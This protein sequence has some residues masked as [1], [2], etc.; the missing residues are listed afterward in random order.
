MTNFAQKEY[1]KI[2]KEN[3]RTVYDLIEEWPKSRWPAVICD[4]L[5]RQA[6]NTNPN[7]GFVKYIA[8]GLNGIA[9]PINGKPKFV[10]PKFI[11][12][13]KDLSILDWARWIFLYQDVWGYKGCK[14]PAK[15][16]EWVNAVDR[17]TGKPIDNQKLLR[18]HEW[19][20]LTDKQ[21]WLVRGTIEPFKFYLTSIGIK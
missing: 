11:P 19:S 16:R 1:E 15:S 14:D 12:N 7:V 9:N 18:E 17:D 6:L 4:E 20:E 13:N 21:L 8:N 10:P 5:L 3:G 2:W